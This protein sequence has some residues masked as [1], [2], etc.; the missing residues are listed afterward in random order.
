MGDKL[1]WLYVSIRVKTIRGSTELPKCCDMKR[2]G[3][4]NVCLTRTIQVK[5]LNFSFI[6][7]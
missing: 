7:F 4:I 5:I 3:H 1:W 6:T 2:I